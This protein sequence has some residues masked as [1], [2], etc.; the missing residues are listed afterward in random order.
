MRSGRF[1]L[2]DFRMAASRVKV[3]ELGSMT[4]E[5]CTSSLSL[6]CRCCNF[7]ALSSNILAFRARA[8]G[9]VTVGVRC[10]DPP[11]SS[12]SNRLMRRRW[13]RQRDP[14]NGEPGNWK[15]RQ[16]VGPFFKHKTFFVY[17]V[18]PE[19]LK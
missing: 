15:A 12:L 4:D 19:D 6:A 16:S 3:L 14:G 11:L 2:I 5:I 18:Q 9:S 17:A 1:S 8:R 7:E 13:A 10:R